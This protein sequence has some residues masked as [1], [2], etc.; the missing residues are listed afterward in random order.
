MR[1]DGKWI[2]VTGGAS[3]SGSEAGSGSAG[4]V[5]VEQSL[6]VTEHLGEIVGRLVARATTIHLHRVRTCP[7]ASRATWPS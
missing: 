4:E 2:I 6:H 7:F 1:L 3:G 5:G